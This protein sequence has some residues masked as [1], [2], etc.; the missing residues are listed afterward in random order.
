M[1]EQQKPIEE[2]QIQEA[3]G[4]PNPSV[5]KKNRWAVQRSLIYTGIGLLIGYFLAQQTTYSLSAVLPALMAIFTAIFLVIILLL[6]ALPRIINYLVNRYTGKKFNVEKAIDDVQSKLNKFADNI[7][8]VALDK[9]N[10]PADVKNNIRSDMPDIIYYF[11]FMWLRSSGLRFLITVFVAIGGLMGTILLYNQNQL[12]QSQNEKIESQNKKID[13]QIQLDEASRRSSLNFLMANVLDKIDQELKQ[14]IDTNNLRQ[15]SDPL[16][17]RIASLT[18]SFR[19]Y[20]FLENGKLTSRELS[21]EKGSFL[22]ALVNSELDSL[23]LQKIFFKSSFRDSYLEGAN[24]LGTHLVGIDLVS[25]DLDRVDFTGA[26]LSEANFTEADLRIA[27]LRG[28]NLIDATFTGADLTKVDFFEANLTRA[29]LSFTNFD[30]VDLEGARLG[31]ANLRGA[32]DL[33]ME[34][35]KSVNSLFFATGID[36]FYDQLKKEKPCLFTQKGCGYKKS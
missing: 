14:Q 4:N 30:R 9:T 21:P 16:I 27:N 36:D 10:A 13:N 32:I 12:L 31:G 22:V 26:N 33:T 29:N 35:L 34:Q 17:G 2:K 19:P 28:A 5:K 8:V 24:L 15:L 20:K 7:A 18:Q 23:T 6:L 1:S 3:S 11:G 25:A